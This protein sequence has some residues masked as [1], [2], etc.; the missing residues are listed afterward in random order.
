M[1]DEVVR[2]E[3]AATE[4]PAIERKP[5][6]ELVANSD[7]GSEVEG[8]IGQAAREEQLA[9][10]I[11]KRVEAAIIRLLADQLPAIVER[12]IEEKIQ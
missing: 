11:S 3:S 10:V 7:V 9:A 12:I 6:E 1:A 2:E 8:N 5:P 4:A